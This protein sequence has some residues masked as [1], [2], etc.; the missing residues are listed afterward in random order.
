[1]VEH[2]LQQLQGCRHVLVE[3]A[4][5]DV[6]VVAIDVD[7]VV[8]GQLVELLFDIGSRQLVG[9]YIVEIVAGNGIAVVVLMAEVIAEDQREEVVVGVLLV[10][11][12]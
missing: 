11:K 4:E 9:A 8:A 6:Q 3:S 1:M 7:A 5:C 10:K 12:G 2:I